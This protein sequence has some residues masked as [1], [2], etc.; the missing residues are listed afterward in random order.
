MA[1]SLKAA[2][3]YD[4]SSGSSSP[5][6]HWAHVLPLGRG[7]RASSATRASSEERRLPRRPTEPGAGLAEW[8]DAPHPILLRTQIVEQRLVSRVGG[9]HFDSVRFLA[10]RLLI[11]FPRE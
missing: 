2:D 9:Y 3:D 5:P 4:A 10:L 1:A 11:T 8:L 7:W 6:P